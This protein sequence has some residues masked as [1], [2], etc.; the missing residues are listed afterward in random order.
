MSNIHFIL[1]I[2]LYAARE[3]RNTIWGEWSPCTEKCFGHNMEMPRR[4]R[5]GTTEN[6]FVMHEEDFCKENIT[7]CPFGKS[8]TH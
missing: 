8:Y 2:D 3:Q 6:G 5:N 1:C 7:I 4:I